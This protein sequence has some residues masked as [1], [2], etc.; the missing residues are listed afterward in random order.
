MLSQRHEGRQ[1]Y[2]TIA[3]IYSGMQQAIVSVAGSIG[4]MA[5][6]EMGAMFAVVPASLDRQMKTTCQSNGTQE[7]SS[8]QASKSNCSQEMKEKKKSSASQKLKIVQEMNNIRIMA[9]AVVF[10]ELSS[11]HG[12]ISCMFYHNNLESFIK[13]LVFCVTFQPQY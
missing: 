3:T 11:S 2:I 13:E 5:G 12:H 6:S 9:S 8:G 1:D 7:S 10:S 4:D